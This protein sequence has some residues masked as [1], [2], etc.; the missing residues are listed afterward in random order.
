MILFQ[1]FFFGLTDTCKEDQYNERTLFYVVLKHAKR[2]LDM[3]GQGR[4]SVASKRA[5]D[6]S[7]EYT[8]FL[9]RNWSP[10]TPFSARKLKG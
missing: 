8:G 5:N 10:Y 2:L 1:D 7:I 9:D 3:S 4:Y 6:R